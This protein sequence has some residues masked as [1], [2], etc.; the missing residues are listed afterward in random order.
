M[1]VNT[2]YK[3]TDFKRALKIIQ[4]STLAVITNENLQTSYM[5]AL[6][7]IDGDGKVKIEF[8]MPHV[9]PMIE[10]LRDG[11]K[12]QVNF[13]GTN[14]Y[15]SPTMYI[16]DGLPT[17]MYECVHVTGIPQEMGVADLNR[18][19]EVLI[20]QEENKL[21]RLM[22]TAKLGAPNESPYDTWTADD[23]ATKRWDRLARH[24]SGFYVISD[25]VEIKSKFGQNRREDDTNNTIR[26]LDQA[27]AKFQKSA[28][29]MREAQL[30]G[31]Q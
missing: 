10:C 11:K 19:L 12:I 6:G 8:H 3:N 26:I 4:E 22:E 7:A 29:I 5:P 18:H 21:K 13:L 27:A 16:D 14:I 1:Y 17:Y 15:T 23:E 9:D 28:S 24:I 31:K 30:R 2:L 20:E 25:N